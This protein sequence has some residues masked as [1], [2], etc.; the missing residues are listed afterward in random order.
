MDVVF[1]QAYEQKTP[2][3]YVLVCIVKKNNLLSWII[4]NK[5]ISN[6]TLNFTSFRYLHLNW[7]RW[8]QAW[9]VVIF[10]LVSHTPGGAGICFW[11]NKSF[12][13]LF[14]PPPC[15]LH[16]FLTW[17]AQFGPRWLSANL[18]GL[19]SCLKCLEY[20]VLDGNRAVLV[21][22]T[23][24]HTNVDFCLFPTIIL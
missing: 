9:S 2:N 16:L 21:T 17:T 18:H 10:E 19:I 5:S 15:P 1:K 12:P 7:V 14:P 13:S 8:F 11:V 3:D 22:H 23:H 20:W 4:K 6:H 24:T